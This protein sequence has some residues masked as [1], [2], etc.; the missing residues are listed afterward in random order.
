MS[1]AQ[2]K[3]DDQVFCYG[4]LAPFPVTNSQP[5]TSAAAKHTKFQGTILFPLEIRKVVHG[6]TIILSPNISVMPHSTDNHS[7]SFHLFSQ[8]G[9]HGFKRPCL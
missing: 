1:K 5:V 7:I 3:F 4:Q 2:E 6:N 9:L 8:G